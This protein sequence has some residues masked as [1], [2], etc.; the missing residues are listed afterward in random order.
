[1]ICLD[2]ELT[3]I[4]NCLDSVHEFRILIKIAFNLAT[5]LES[6]NNICLDSGHGF[7]INKICLNSGHEFRILMR[8]AL[9]LALRLES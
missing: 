8:F 4:A 5:S 2:S 6:S 9:T 3:L 7:T 1:M